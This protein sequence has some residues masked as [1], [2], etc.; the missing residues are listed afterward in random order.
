MRNSEVYP[1][2]TVKQ[3]IF[4]IRFPNLFYLESR[5]G[6]YQVRIMRD[7]PESRLIFQRSLVVASGLP[8]A[9][10][11]AYGEGPQGVQGVQA[12]VAAPQAGPQGPQDAQDDA[13]VK[14]WRFVSSAGVELNVHTDSLSLTSRLHKTY[15]NPTHEPRFRDAIKAA[16]DPFL[17][18]T[19]VP[20]ITRIGLRYIDDCPVFERKDAVYKESYNTTFPLRRFRLSEASEMAFRVRTRRGKHMLLFSESFSDQ[21]GALK[22]VLDFDAYT[23]DAR[24]GNYL[25]AADELYD[26]ISKEYQVSIKERVREF[27]R[28][29]KGTDDD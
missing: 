20:V 28:Q 5:I 11:S 3:V 18:V 10:H 1:N 14:T 24:P 8:F 13:V 27:M 23:H 17:E 6:E 22:L 16:V 15:A 21:E 2:P 4:Q 19:S 25:E 7:F 12:S 9:I 26:I 29:S